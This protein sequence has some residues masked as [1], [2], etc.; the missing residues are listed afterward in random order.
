MAALM[1]AASQ[2]QPGEIRT[3]RTWTG[4]VG[5]WTNA[6]QWGGLVPAYN[7]WAH[8]QSSGTVTIDT[9][10][11]TAERVCP[12]LTSGL[13]TLIVTNGGV[14][15]A[16]NYNSTAQGV[17]MQGATTGTGVVQV[18]GGKIVASQ[19]VVARAYDGVF[20]V[21]SG[22]VDIWNKLILS[23]ERA[24]GSNARFEMNGGRLTAFDLWCGGQ[25]VDG[26][27]SV[28]VIAGGEIELKEHLVIG[29]GNQVHSITQEGGV[30]NVQSNFHLGYISWIDLGDGD[31]AYTLNGG[32]LCVNG[33]MRSHKAAARSVQ[34]NLNGGTLCFRT[35][36]DTM[37]GLTNNGACL[38]PGYTNIGFMNH[39]TYFS[40]YTE[41]SEKCSM[42]LQLA[43]T[44]HPALGGVAGA[45]DHL[46]SAN[47]VNIMGRLLISFLDGFEDRV[48]RDDVFYI[49]D[50][51]NIN[52]QFA[53][54]ANGQRVETLNN[55]GSFLVT[56]PVTPAAPL[57][58]M[59]KA[60]MLSD[61]RPPARG[62]VML[63]R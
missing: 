6:A 8:I 27:T 34:F 17:W 61:Y 28:T 39:G 7:E 35:Y 16:T 3:A 45:Y 30:V 2:A 29:S 59:P 11:A 52:G 44:N 5:N 18:A 23:E 60:V 21:D 14:L 57:N 33:E 47:T 41:T 48:T 1:L 26:G 13:S 51:Q 50:A 24:P 58:W 36:H 15:Y 32:V 37:P 46:H 38:S 31:F 20:R 40:P 42:H 55:N 25:N 4:G 49:L 9:P 62:T 53:N 22:E 54:A 63:M 56:Y 43:G 12:G 10:D 19:V